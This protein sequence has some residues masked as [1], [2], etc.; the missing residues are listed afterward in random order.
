VARIGIV[1][2]HHPLFGRRFD[3]SPLDAAQRP[4][5]V[6]IVLDDG[7]RR[8]VPR[9]ATDL[10]GVRESLSSHALPCVS[11]RTLLALM[12]YVQT[13][14]SNSRVLDG[15]PLHPDQLESQASPSDRAADAGAESV[16]RNDA[17]SSAASGAAV[18]SAASSDVGGDRRA[19]RGGSC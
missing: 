17:G 8:W 9:A 12:Q 4:G 19:E 13:L 11:V 6:S 3:L 7:R 2:P 16:A 5:W 14:H 1:D 10:D 18:G 15:S